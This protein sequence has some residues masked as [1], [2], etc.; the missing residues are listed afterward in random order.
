MRWVAPGNRRSLRASGGRR[1]GGAAVHLAPSTVG[2]Q[3]GS[4]QLGASLLEIP[5]GASTFPLHF[6]HANEVML[7]VVARRPT[8]RTL[9]GERELEPGE[10]LAFPTG[11]R[12]AHRARARRRWR[13][14]GGHRHRPRWQRP[15][16]A[17]GPM[18]AD[19]SLPLGPER[20]RVCWSHGF[21]RPVPFGLSITEF[22]ALDATVGGCLRRPRLAVLRTGTGRTW[23]AR[24][25]AEAR[26]R[27]A[28]AAPKVG[29]GAGHAQADAGDDLLAALISA[30]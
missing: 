22:V 2:R 7:L 24:L 16:A 27:R 18:S 26:Q 15:R 23:R 1:T 10:I 5:P 19:P 20:D 14:P 21:W 13:P 12:G 11:R 4:E 25:G 8:L 30:A 17:S 28:C 29:W 6:H 9:E 3:A